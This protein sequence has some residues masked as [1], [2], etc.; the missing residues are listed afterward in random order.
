MMHFLEEYQPHY[1]MTACTLHHLDSCRVWCKVKAKAVTYFKYFNYIMCQKYIYMTQYHTYIISL[2]CKTVTSWCRLP[3]DTLF[4][5]I[6][7][8]SWHMKC[9]Y[10]T[11]NSLLLGHT[12]IQKS[13]INHHILSLL[14]FK[15]VVL[16][17]SH[18][19]P[20]GPH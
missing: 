18:M 8:L 4:N 13:K 6:S 12:K 14:T 2:L 11:H 3:S 17:V 1:W 19:A 9:F 5:K 15:L 7:H 16:E 10:H 20:S